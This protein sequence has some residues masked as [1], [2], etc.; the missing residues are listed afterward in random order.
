MRTTSRATF[1]AA[2]GALLLVSSCGTEEIPT[3]ADLRLQGEHH[4][5]AGQWLQAAEAYRMAYALVDPVPDRAKVRADLALRRGRALA[6][7]GRAS[8][9]SLWLARA[10]R[11]DP[12]RYEVLY[13]IARI[14]DGPHPELVDPDRAREY[15]EHFLKAFAVS[16]RPAAF[17]GLATH[18]TKRVAALEPK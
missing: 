11:L 5:K 16:G 3:A 2:L 13:D 10:Q 1:L 8:V 18:A 15:Y 12:S 4:A 6:M 17:E 14:H 9:G 7:A